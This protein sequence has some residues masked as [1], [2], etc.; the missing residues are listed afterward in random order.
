MK[1]RQAVVGRKMNSLR[2]EI[3]TSAR[4]YLADRLA[5]AT[6][7]V[8]ID[9]RVAR[10]PPTKLALF[11]RSSSRA[12]GTTAAIHVCMTSPHL[13]FSNAELALVIGG[14][15]LDPSVP[16]QSRDHLVAACGTQI[17][18]YTDARKA[19]AGAP[20]D[21]R[22]EIDAAAAGRSLA[23]CAMKHGFD[24]LPQWRYAQSRR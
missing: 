21:T 10:G 14:A 6:H 1:T 9:A 3:A 13:S 19:A 23:V 4:R 20:L 24:P 7:I 15:K 5:V 22:K 11:H 18:A 17:D 16:L 12:A 8:P 2:R